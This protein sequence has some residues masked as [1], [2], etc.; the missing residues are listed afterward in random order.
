MEREDYVFNR[1]YVYTHDENLNLLVDSVWKLENLSPLVQSMRSR[2]SPDFTLPHL[3]KGSSLSRGSPYTD[4]MR[5]IVRS[6]YEVD[7]ELFGYD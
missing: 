7:F 5:K 2:I 4:E 1:Q 6:V 3:N